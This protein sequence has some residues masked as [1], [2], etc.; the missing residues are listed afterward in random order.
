MAVS[1]TPILLLSFSLALAACGPEKS[2]PPASSSQQSTAPARVVWTDDRDN[3]ARIDRGA[4]VTHRTGEVNLQMTPV[5]AI[6]SDGRSPWATPRG[7]IPWSTTIALAAPADV[8]SM[9]L[10]LR[11]ARTR[12]ASKF[13]VEVSTD[14]ETFTDAGELTVAE[15]AAHGRIDR[16]AVRAIRLTSRP[17]EGEMMTAVSEIVVYGREVAPWQPPSLAGTWR[18]NGTKLALSD[19]GGMVRGATGAEPPTLLE[20]GWSGRSIRFAWSRGEEFGVGVMAVDPSARHLNALWWNLKPI[21]AFFGSS[22]LGSREAGTQAPAI[23]GSVMDVFLRRD[24]R[25]PLYGISFEDDGTLS[26]SSAGAVRALADLLKREPER[27]RLVAHEVSEA[28]ADADRETARRH[29]LTLAAALEREGV[30]TIATHAAGRDA[31]EHTPW[32]PV[33]KLLYNRIDL[34]LV[35]GTAAPEPKGGGVS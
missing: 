12:T 4:V 14:G 24:G 26:A 27:Y 28:G 33:Q 32:I 31:M 34:Q 30:A 18:V 11:G 23:R 22:W 25:Y 15:T 5:R 9:A 20:G 17:A 1:R 19:A 2:F 16:P 35:S 21:E 6:D 8:S 29:L 10:T 7:P 3:L 13:G